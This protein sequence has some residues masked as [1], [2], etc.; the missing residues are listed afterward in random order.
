MWHYSFPTSKI[1]S[2][3]IK[4]L[5]YFY[6]ITFYFVSEFDFLIF[7]NCHCYLKKFHVGL[8]LQM[9]VHIRNVYIFS[10]SKLLSILN[11][12]FKALENYNCVIFLSTYFYC[13]QE[14]QKNYYCPNNSFSGPPLLLS[15][16]LLFFPS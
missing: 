6:L 10:C 2:L 14:S 8:M 16:C 1:N 9:N 12:L 13:G 11:G 4:Y 7:L 5:K 3:S 15:W